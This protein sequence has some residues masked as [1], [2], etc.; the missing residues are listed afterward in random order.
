MIEDD[1]QAW[2]DSVTVVDSSSE[3]IAE[4]SKQPF[5]T[6][7]G[8]WVTGSS[9]PTDSPT[10]AKTKH[11]SDAESLVR[12]R[13]ADDIASLDA[14]LCISLRS[15]DSKNWRIHGTPELWRELFYNVR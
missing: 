6:D 10:D 7:P 8:N 5:D 15:D 13:I 3:S 4:Q 2:T 1:V 12:R 9:N 11:I 14:D